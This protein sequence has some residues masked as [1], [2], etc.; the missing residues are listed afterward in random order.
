[1]LEFAPKGPGTRGQAEGAEEV[2]PMNGRTKG[3]GPITRV[4]LSK[5]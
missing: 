1:M 3:F 2:L 5:R 4:P